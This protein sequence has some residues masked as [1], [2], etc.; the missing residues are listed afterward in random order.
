MHEAIEKDYDSII[1]AVI[2]LKNLATEHVDTIDEID[3]EKQIL[4][5][6]IEELVETVENLEK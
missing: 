6:T 3:E 1:D 5:V 4:R 2:K